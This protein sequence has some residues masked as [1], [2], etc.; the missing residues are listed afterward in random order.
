MRIFPQYIR[1]LPLDST[2]HCTVCPEQDIVSIISLSPKNLLVILKLA[3]FDFRLDVIS[4]L[5]SQWTSS[6]GFFDKLYEKEL[7]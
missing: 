1:F 3:L 4:N 2:N 7:K 6:F 5:D